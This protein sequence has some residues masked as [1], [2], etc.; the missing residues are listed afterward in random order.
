MP[1]DEPIVSHGPFVMNTVAE[2]HE[3]YADYQ[4]GKFSAPVNVG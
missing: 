2:I 4:A 1:S 3:A